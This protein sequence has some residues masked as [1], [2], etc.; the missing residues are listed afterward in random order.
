MQHDL[1]V[2]VPSFG[3]P[4]KEQ[5][6][7]QVNHIA[8]RTLGQLWVTRNIFELRQGIRWFHPDSLGVNFRVT[9]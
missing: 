5:A 8:R 9:L 3:S 2:Y 1:E 7:A 4:R 6:R